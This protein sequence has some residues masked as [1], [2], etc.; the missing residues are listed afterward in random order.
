VQ[1]CL[2]LPSNLVSLPASEN[3]RL[4]TNFEAEYE[5]ESDINVSFN[6][7]DVNSLMVDHAIHGPI[8]LS[9]GR[10]LYFH[11]RGKYYSER[12]GMETF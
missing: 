3:F 4:L 1:L 11:N 10:Y 6:H 5:L 7:R 12:S 9:G 2:E 8:C